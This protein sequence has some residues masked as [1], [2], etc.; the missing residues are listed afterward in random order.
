MHTRLLTN[1][2]AF[3][4]LAEEWQALLGRAL[5]SSVFLTWTW[6]RT[7]WHHLGK[8]D[9]L[10]VTVRDDT[11]QLVGIAPLF[12]QTTSLGLRQLSLVGCVDVSDYLDL[13]VDRRCAD[14]VYGSIW[15]FLASPEC[16]AWHEINLCN[17]PRTSVTPASL[18]E[19]AQRSGHA[20]AVSVADVCPVITL[21]TS[22]E[23]Y[24]ASLD[25]KQ[26]HELRRK[27]R[28]IQEEAQP[29]WYVVEG[30]AG[31]PQ[32]VESFI[33]LH[34][35]SA[36]KKE[37]FWDEAMKS[38]FRAIAA[39]LSALSWLKLYFIELNG[40]RAASV[41]CFDYQNEILVYNS[42][43]DPAQFAHL[44]PG[45][46]LVGYCIQHAIQLGR[47]RFDFLRGDED[48]KFRFGAIPEPVSRLHILRS[49]MSS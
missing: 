9:L 20:A 22:W 33:D 7:W 49:P 19:L 30:G 41:F 14:P 21:P 3:D 39:S 26:R 35:K 48:Y 1:A 17:L 44:S 36:A 18:G 47:T 23:E 40:V 32:D 27:L 6:Q 4:G 37:G 5:V 42:G 24:L 38:F 12:L 8:G 29:R 10:L 13:I 28:R 31:L 15:D 34:Q 25:K 43:Y 2:E 45:I 16:P 11:G 46:V